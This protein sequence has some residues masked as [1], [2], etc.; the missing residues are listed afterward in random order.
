MRVFSEYEN[1]NKEELIEAEM[2]KIGKYELVRKYIEMNKF[3]IREVIG[4]RRIIPEEFDRVQ[5]MIG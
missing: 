1:F 5:K 2:I 4:E 3:E